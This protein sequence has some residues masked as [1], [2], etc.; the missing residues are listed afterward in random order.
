MLVCGW[1]VLLQ[2]NH[3]GE[4]SLTLGVVLSSKDPQQILSNTTS[5]NDINITFLS[6]CGV[7]A[8]QNYFP[9]LLCLSLY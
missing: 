1:S 2:H 6:F 8:K 9:D 7:T 4:E 3:G 5:T